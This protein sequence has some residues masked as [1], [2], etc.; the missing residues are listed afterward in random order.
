M[1]KKA[2]RALAAKWSEA[3]SRVAL[4]LHLGRV[5]DDEDRACLRAPTR[6]SLNVGLHDGPHLHLAGA[7]KAIHG[8]EVRLRAGEVR[9]A[10]LRRRPQL[11]RDLHQ[12][13]FTSTV[14]EICSDE[15]L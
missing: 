11:P 14:S 13:G 9:Q 6:S 8:R 2:A 10:L 3:A 7:E 12:A 5:V 15:L 1:Q 4:E